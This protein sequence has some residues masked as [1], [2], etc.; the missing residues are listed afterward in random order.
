MVHTGSVVYK[1]TLQLVPPPTPDNFRYPIVIY[2]VRLLYVQ[3]ITMP[4]Y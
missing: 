4:V 1:V 3:C 2:L